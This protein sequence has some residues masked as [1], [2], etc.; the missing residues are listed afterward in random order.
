MRTYKNALDKI[1][2]S[3]SFKNETVN[4]L[5]E[6]QSRS[7]KYRFAPIAAIAASL[8]V[9]I[10]LGAIFIPMTKSHNSFVIKAN[11]AEL[12][13]NS[14]TT[15]GE[16]PASGWWTEWDDNNSIISA[17]AEAD[18]MLSVKGENIKEITYSIE[19]GA[20]AVPNINRK[21][22]KSDKVAKAGYMP[23]RAGKSYYSTVTTSYNNQFD[24]SNDNV[25]V[26][27]NASVDDGFIR[28]A[29]SFTN[30]EG[31]LW[32]DEVNKS[33]VEKYR[34]ITEAYFNAA[35]KK[36]GFVVRIKY[37]DGTEQEQKVQLSTEVKVETHPQ[38]IME[39]NGKEKTGVTYVAVVKLNAKL[40]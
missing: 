19:N 21:I 31:V 12:N 22:L 34:D 25:E 35:L 20:F 29:E 13:K 4:M 36:C 3:E 14:F 23:N 37:D 9:V 40:L 15:I 26:M 18:F 16:L 2:A 5:V 28:L 11:A 24:V 39:Q 7:R 1:K 32:V 27:L 10:A 17:G 8:A 38:T 6:R 33:E 30:I